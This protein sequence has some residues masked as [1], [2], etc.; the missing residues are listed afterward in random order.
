MPIVQSQTDIAKQA[1]AQMV[2]LAGGLGT[3][4]RPLTE[5]IPKAMIKIRGKPFLEHQLELIKKNGI[6]DIV[7]CVGHLSELIQDYFKDGS[8]FGVSIRYS[9]E[10]GSLLGTAGALKNAEFLL[11]DEFLVMY[12][13]SYLPIDYVEVLR[14]FK[15]S[16]KRGLMMVYKNQGKYDAS[17][18]RIEGGMVV[19]YDKRGG[20]GMEYIDYGLSVLNKKA[21]DH[22]PKGKAYDLGSL[23]KDLIE[24]KQL[25]A[26]E[27]RQRF[28]EAGSPAGLAD[29]EDY[30]N[31]KGG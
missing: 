20:I 6:F 14:H 24:K 8:D 28:Y 5:R 18:V 31:K 3:R 16:G 23:Y 1:A 4:M 15:E 25:A 10:T 17:N 11:S 21:L 9:T 29:L 2:I 26:F 30:L 12:G 7:L 27:T 19:G 13:D 22:V